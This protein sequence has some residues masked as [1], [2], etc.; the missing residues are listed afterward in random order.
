VVSLWTF[1]SIAAVFAGGLKE[2]SPILKGIDRCRISRWSPERIYGVNQ[3]D[4]A[5]PQT[6][7]NPLLNPA[8]SVRTETAQYGSC[9]RRAESWE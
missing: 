4:S 1:E 5:S 7:P 3:R 6:L 8:P 2:R 9:E